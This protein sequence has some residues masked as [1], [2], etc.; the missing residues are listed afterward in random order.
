MPEDF[1]GGSSSYVPWNERGI[2]EWDVPLT[3]EERDQRYQENLES[4]FAR[5]E[6]RALKFDE[7]LRAAQ[8]A[9]EQAIAQMY[10]AARTDTEAQLRAAEQ[11]SV[12]DVHGMAAMAGADPSRLR[13]ASQAASTARQDYATQ[14]ELMR[15]VEEQAQRQAMADLH[16]RGVDYALAGGQAAS[17][18]Y[19]QAAREAAARSERQAQEEI[20]KNQEI[21]GYIGTGFSVAGAGIG[22]AGKASDRSLKEQIEEASP[23]QLQSAM[24][25]ISAA[26]RQRLRPAEADQAA[27]GSYLEGSERAEQGVAGRRTAVDFVRPSRPSYQPVW[28]M[29]PS[30]ELVA[31]DRPA[32]ARRRSAAQIGQR[33]EASDRETMAELAE[34]A[35]GYTYEYSPQ[36][37]G[38]PLTPS[39]EQFGPMAQD[40]EQSELGRTMVTDTPAGK[41]VDTNR[42]ALGSLSLAAEA[43]R[44]VDELEERLGSARDLPDQDEIDRILTRGYQV[45]GV[46]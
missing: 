6:K 14:G 13:A 17:Q 19:G 11:Q 46:R 25:S 33:L 10:G 1:F 16:G 12:A 34:N 42:A 28:E 45:E 22:A 21:A 8:M 41:V 30:G 26:Q 2:N 37:R 7:R 44:R 15:S 31:L 23:E 27:W 29:L 38:G 40:L 39:G 18:L 32:S 4:D 9:E 43:N 3:G 35:P 36:Y 24:R 20:A 5:S